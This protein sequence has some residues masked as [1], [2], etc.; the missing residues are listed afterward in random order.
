MSSKLQI[1]L[2]IIPSFILLLN[3]SKIGNKIGLMDFPDNKR[4]IHK[5]PVP[6]VGGII[7][8]LSLIIYLILNL[9]NIDNYSSII[10]ISFFFILGL[11]DDFKDLSSNSRL[12]L[13]FIFLIIFFNFEK[14]ILI[15]NIKIFNK[16]LNLTIYFHH[17]VI[18]LLTTLCVLLLQNAINMMDG[19]N[20]VC[21]LFIIFCLILF[22]IKT[23]FTLLDGIIILNLIIF[24]AFNYKNKIFLGNSGAY[25]LSSYLAFKI[26]YQNYFNYN[27]T[28]EQI[29]LILMIPGL[30][31]LRLFI[32]RISKK[33]NPFEA[34][35]DHLHHLI[36]KY[37]NGKYNL[38][39]FLTL[40]ITFI[41]GLI[42]YLFNFQS[43]HLI[44]SFIFLYSLLILKLKKKLF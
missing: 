5:N 39:I 13:S 19:I 30:D 12:V 7:V 17:I 34:D 26:L 37:F 1:L 24:T 42:D 2:T 28:A 35:K 38:S 4:K 3:S 16:D 36:L 40:I 33:Q 22:C 18:L 44:F 31:M 29:F 11:I 32:F 9:Q 15:N 14:E 6:K 43:Y 21:S 20:T 41:P 8:Y 23:S 25:L 27:Y 10:F